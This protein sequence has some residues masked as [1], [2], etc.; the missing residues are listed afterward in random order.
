MQRTWR[1]ACFLLALLSLPAL[2]DEVRLA[3]GDRISGELKAKTGDK[4]VVS[5]SY[6]GD[7]EIRWSEVVSVATTHPVELMLEGRKS[8]LR[9]VLQPLYGS[10]ALVV[11]DKGGAVEIALRDVALLNPKPYKS[12]RGVEYTGRAL[13]SAAYTR[14]NA[15]SSQ[16]QGDAEF[17]ARAKRYRYGV[18]GKL[19]RRDERTAG[20]RTA[21]LAGA[22]YDRFLDERRFNYVR[23][24]VEHDRAKDI[25]RRT[26]LGGG[27]GL[28]L[29][30]S[31]AASLS[32]R[33]GLDYVT[34]KRL[35]AA[36]E[37][38]PAAGW[39]VKAGFAPWGPRIQLFHEHEGFW[40]L[41][42]RA[43]V[44]LRSKTG[45]RVPITGGLNATAQ[46]NV[47]WD[48]TP[49]PGRAATD[50]TLLFGVDYAF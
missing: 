34:V 39:G 24:S 26:A 16:L 27:H 38:Y 45:L 31:P 8:P 44:V 43:S 32:V 29:L 7:I 47:D 37:G 22:H 15:Q 21:W 18:S 6:A 12:G 23:G 36:D 40:N 19:D 10:G 14:G 25:D 20:A 30:D 28:Q 35:A 41:E 33:A 11:D 49:A 2:A 48:R 5:T 50:S 42:D 13:L 9:G 46:L 3:N 1:S 17:N 4:L